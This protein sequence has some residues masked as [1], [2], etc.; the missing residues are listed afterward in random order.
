MQTIV[1]RRATVQDAARVTEIYNSNPLFLE[2]HPG[3]RRVEEAFVLH[4]MQEM[5]CTGFSS[6]LFVDLPTGNIVGMADMKADSC[7]YLSLMMLDSRFQQSGKGT[8]CYALLE[9]ELRKCGAHTVRI[10]VV[11]EYPE[12]AKGFWTKQEFLPAGTTR[13]LWGGKESEAIVMH[14]QLD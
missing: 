5:E 10:D 2:H 6:Y 12:N 1:L 11:C 4:E 3:R 13:L 8:L 9:Q 7:A 14:K